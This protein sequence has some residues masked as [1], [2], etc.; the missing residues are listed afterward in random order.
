MHP[1]QLAAFKETVWWQVVAGE[2]QLTAML[3]HYLLNH[4]KLSHCPDYNF[5]Q[6]LKRVSLLEQETIYQWLLAIGVTL[7]S[8]TIK[9]TMWRQEQLLIKEQVGEQWY[10][11]AL[12][13]GL[14]LYHQPIESIDQWLAQLTINEHYYE[15]LLVVGLMVWRAC[16]ENPAAGWWQRLQLKLPANLALDIISPLPEQVEELVALNKI[17]EKL[18]HQVCPHVFD[19]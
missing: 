14:F 13:N 12:S 6:P 8:H 7:H 4:L 5:D 1:S 19:Y 18:L 17:L 9:Q 16:L 11:F 2:S 10:H 15:Q 3:D